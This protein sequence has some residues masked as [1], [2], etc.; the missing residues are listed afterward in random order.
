MGSFQISGKKTSKYY[1]IFLRRNYKRIS[2]VFVG[3][4]QVRTCLET[5]IYQLQFERLSGDISKFRPGAITS[6]NFMYKKFQASHL[7]HAPAVQGFKN[8]MTSEVKSKGH[9]LKKVS[10]NSLAKAKKACAKKK[11]LEKLKTTS[12]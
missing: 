8:T 5:D 9:S 10:K 7:C 2:K 4:I 6:S 1:A 3:K 11:S 12:E